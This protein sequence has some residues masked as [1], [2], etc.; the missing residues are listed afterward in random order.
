[1]AFKIDINIIEL[2]LIVYKMT[3]PEGIFQIYEWK[4]GGSSSDSFN[5]DG[6][7]F[8]PNKI[9]N[10]FLKCHRKVMLLPEY[11]SVQHG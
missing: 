7:T 8:T 6:F 2:Y 3:A 1:M 10:Y 11:G 5:T 9:I 4:D